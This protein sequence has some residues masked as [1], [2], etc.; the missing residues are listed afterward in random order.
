MNA[1]AGTLD[2]FAPEQFRMSRLQVFNWGTFS[3]LHSRRSFYPGG[4]FTIAQVIDQIIPPIG[5]PSL[6]GLPIGHVKNKLT[7]PIGIK[8]ELDVNN[9]LLTL[10]E[11]SVV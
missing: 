5:K 9:N 10:L 8:A 1:K 4:S 11:N 7:L 6:L 2:L 3:G